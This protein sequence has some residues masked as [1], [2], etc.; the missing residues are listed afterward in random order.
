MYVFGAV[1]DGP[2]WNWKNF[3]ALQH[4]GPLGNTVSAGD[5]ALIDVIKHLLTTA[6]RLF[7]YSVDGSTGS[8]R[9]TATS[10]YQS[11]HLRAGRWSDEAR[12]VQD[13]GVWYLYDYLEARGVDPASAVHSGVAAG[14]VGSQCWPVRMYGNI[15]MVPWRYW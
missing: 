8:P 13:M 14:S 3:T 2:T 7:V 12:R 4:L 5:L 10:P 9:T 1:Q 6:Q 11:A 15:S